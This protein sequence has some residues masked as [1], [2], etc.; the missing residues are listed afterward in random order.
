M[1]VEAETCRSITPEMLEI[2]ARYA[3]ESCCLPFKA[4]LGHFMKAA[5][6]GV[7]YAVMVNSIGP[8]RLR[9]YGRL[10]QKI[11]RDILHSEWGRLFQNWEKLALPP[12]DL[13]TPGW[14]NVGDEPAELTKEGMKFF[15]ESF[16]ILGLCV[17]EAPEFAAKKRLKAAKPNA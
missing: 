9:Y 7:E 6:D 13:K 3:P 14:A 12:D 16:R 11:I 5:M 15:L 2:G 4:Y 1:D 17:K 10:H 8:C